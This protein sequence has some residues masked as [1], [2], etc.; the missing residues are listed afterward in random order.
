MNYWYIVSCRHRHDT[1]YFSITGFVIHQPRAVCIPFVGD[2][3]VLETGHQNISEHLKFYQESATIFTA[4]HFTAYLRGNLTQTYLHN[5][6]ESLLDIQLMGLLPDSHC[7]MTKK[8]LSCWYKDFRKRD[9]VSDCFR[10]MKGIPIPCNLSC[11]HVNTP[12]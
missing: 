7:L 3:F 5:L 11:Y 4:K 9:M 2:S 6:E 8:A 1:A 10:W 12:Q